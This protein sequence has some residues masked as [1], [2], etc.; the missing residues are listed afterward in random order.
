MRYTVQVPLPHLL[1]AASEGAANMSAPPNKATIMAS[2]AMNLLMNVPRV[3]WRPTSPNPRSAYVP[4]GWWIVVLLMRTPWP[5]LRAT[6][7][8]E[9]NCCAEALP[10][11]PHR[12][13]HECAPVR[14]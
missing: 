1:V 12:G 3:R 8:A 9:R 10:G 2:V 13:A 7:V 5:V 6:G 11:A 4:G 14:G